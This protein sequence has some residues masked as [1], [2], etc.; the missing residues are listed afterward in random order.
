VSKG[1]LGI[2]G[3][4]LPR[5]PTSKSELFAVSTTEWIPSAGIEA[6]PVATAAT[7]LDT[8]I[9]PFAPSATRTAFEDSAIGEFRPLRGNRSVPH[10]ADGVSW[11]SVL[12]GSGRVNGGE[13]I[14]LHSA[15]FLSRRFAFSPKRS[16]I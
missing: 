16:R 9:A 6:L 8:A 14:R 11:S 3:R 13:A 1:M 15:S 10:A 5:R 2:G 7:N 12:R 4:W